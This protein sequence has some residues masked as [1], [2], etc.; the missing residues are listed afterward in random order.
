MPHRSIRVESVSPSLTEAEMPAIPMNC[1]NATLLS[2]R[3]ILL[4][5]GTVNAPS[6]GR[7]ENRAHVLAVAQSLPWCSG[8]EMA[9]WSRT[10]HDR[11][12]PTLALVR[13][14]ASL[15]SRLSQIRRAAAC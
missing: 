14:W 13:T 5:K 15:P 10:F 2:K 3:D 1:L 11:S 8:E 7:V 9:W 6:A 4:P 12:A